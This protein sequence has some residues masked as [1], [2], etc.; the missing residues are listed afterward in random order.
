MWLRAV[1]HR[2][3][4][5]STA[6]LVQLMGKLTGPQALINTSSV[7]GLSWRG[8][9]SRPQAS[10]ASPATLWLPDQA[11]WGNGGLESGTLEP[12]LHRAQWH[13]GLPLQETTLWRGQSLHSSREGFLGL[14]PAPRVSTAGAGGTHITV[15]PRGQGWGSALWQ[16]GL[17]NRILAWGW[18]DNTLKAQGEARDPRSRQLVCA[19]QHY[20]CIW[21][22][23]PSPCAQG[24]S[25]S[26]WGLRGSK[27]TSQW[28]W[29]SC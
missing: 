19:V 18:N 27:H 22:S 8:L 3:A 6:L 10:A 25:L 28:S 17:R 1:L 4:G 20:A 5:P 14:Q 29:L 16:R 26:L 13:H 2:G 11:L 7:V 9:S 12:R 15:K 21:G 23:V 24:G